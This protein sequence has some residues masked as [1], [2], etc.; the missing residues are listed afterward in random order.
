MTNAN[1]CFL[2]SNMPTPRAFLSSPTTLLMEPSPLWVAW[3]MVL[4]FI[5][6]S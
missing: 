4:R 2:R 6:A 1:D 5:S 3:T